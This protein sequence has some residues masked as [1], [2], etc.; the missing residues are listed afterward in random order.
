MGEVKIDINQEFTGTKAPTSPTKRKR[1]A[2]LAS[3]RLK[4]K[5]IQIKKSESP[6]RFRGNYFEGGES[7]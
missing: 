1:R 5:I 6:P 7:A 4:A 2:L 3:K